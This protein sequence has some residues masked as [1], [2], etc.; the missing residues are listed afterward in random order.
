MTWKVD[1]AALPEELRWVNALHLPHEWRDGIIG[2]QRQK[3]TNPDKLP[4]FVMLE[5]I[6]HTL[7][8]EIICFLRGVFKENPHYRTHYWILAESRPEVPTLD[9]ERLFIAVREW[10]KAA[11]PDGGGKV[12]ATKIKPSEL[13]WER[14]DLVKLLESNLSLVRSVLPGVLSRWLL[15]NRTELW[16]SGKEGQRHGGALRLVPSPEAKSDLL[17]WPPSKLLKRDSHGVENS[18]LYSYLVTL[19]STSIPGSNELYVSCHPGVRRWA[20]RPLAEKE[21]GSRVWLPWGRK[22]HV[23]VARQSASW[24]TKQKQTA[25]TTLLDLQLVRYD[26]VSWFGWIPGLLA[27][28]DCREAVPDPLD[29]LRDLKHY[30]PNCLLVYDTS[31]T[32]D[33]KVAAGLEL[34]DRWAV[35]EQMRSAMPEGITAIE[36]WPKCREYVR[37]HPD[38]ASKGFKQ[39]VPAI[40]QG[41]FER[42]QSPAVIEICSPQPEKLEA[43]IREMFPL[44]ERPEEDEGTAPIRIARSNLEPSLWGPLPD[45]VALTR[46]IQVQLR[47]EAMRASD[48]EGQ[49]V[50]A[51]ANVGVLVEMPHYKQIY[52]IGSPEQRRDPKRAVRWGLAR[53]QRLSQFFR[54]EAEG[55]ESY[56][57]RVRSS[58]RDLLRQMGYSYNDLYTGF[59]RTDSLPT[60]VDLI[61]LWMMRL[62]KR[63]RTEY[64]VSL[65]LLIH[66]AA[67]DPVKRVCLPGENGPQWYSEREAM[68]ALPDLT[69][70][71]TTNLRDIA[72]FEFFERAIADMSIQGDAL[73]L[74][75]KNNMGVSNFI[76]REFQDAFLTSSDF[77]IGGATANHPHLRIARLRYATEREVPPVYP[78]PRGSKQEDIEMSFG[79]F[80]GLY[81]GEMQSHVFYSIQGRPHTAAR[82][83]GI[84]QA[85]AQELTSWNPVALE[86]TLANLQENDVPGEWAWLV[87]RLREASTHFDG[88][89]DLPEPLYSASL[90]KE[91][92]LRLDDSEFD[93]EQVGN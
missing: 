76:Y 89:T 47:A 32:E 17:T 6:L 5:S 1:L 31:M 25:S 81:G 41:A 39:V 48:I 59:R 20:S 80:K 3:D 44:I 42:M 85:D 24:L 45:Y 72:C 49:L 83:T 34:A 4:P 75:S 90:L 84:R 10:L 68:L 27:T 69:D 12:M 91:Y 62:K 93:L 86:I 29:L 70:R 71:P 22:K 82:P 51:K 74:L 43:V 11:Y 73:L 2:L 21:N 92:V 14:L 8:P 46:D 56:E 79:Q 66:A 61:G 60:N 38:Y 36:P 87:H 78:V 77:H 30:Q 40:R 58:I 63:N 23:Y 57:M 88:A 28:L 67:G 64:P 37:L 19:N 16:L 18:H 55:P 7:A 33:H 13:Q 52:K 54:P 53:T 9:P 65:P 26:E 15:H 50:P 35:F